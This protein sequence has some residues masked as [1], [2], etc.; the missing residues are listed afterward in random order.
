MTILCDCV[1]S[2]TLDI[3]SEVYVELRI[4]DRFKN[5]QTIMMPIHGYNIINLIGKKAIKLK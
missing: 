3:D 4:L 2:G 5:E 1:D